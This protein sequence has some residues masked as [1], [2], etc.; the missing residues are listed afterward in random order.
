MGDR[1]YY[2][3]DGSYRGSSSD[4]GPWDHLTKIFIVLF[5]FAVISR[6][7]R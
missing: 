7:C 1:H 5:L 4:Q 3:P 2:G 6:G